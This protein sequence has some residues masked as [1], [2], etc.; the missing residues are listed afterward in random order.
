MVFVTDC[1][2]VQVLTVVAGLAGA[3]E[4]KPGKLQIGV[5]KRVEV[6]CRAVSG[7]VQY[8]DLPCAGLRGEEQEGRLAL[9]ALH[10]Q[11]AR[12]HGVRQQHPQVALRQS[13]DEG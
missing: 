5:K 2:L 6:R 7:E 8:S 12:R 9:H 3:E 4:K 10:R 11:A 1:V 13:A